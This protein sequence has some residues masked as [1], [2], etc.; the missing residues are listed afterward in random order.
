MMRLSRLI[1]MCPREINFMKKQLLIWF[2][3]AL[4]LELTV[5]NYRTWMTMG[6]TPVS[7]ELTE[8]KGFEDEGDGWYR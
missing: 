2:V 6:S 5:F 7:A 4:I 3:L 8:T 1:L